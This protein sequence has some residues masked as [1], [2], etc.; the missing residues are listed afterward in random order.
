MR[1][2]SPWRTSGDKQGW[3]RWLPVRYEWFN[4]WTLAL[5]ELYNGAHCRGSL[6]FSALWEWTGGNGLDLVP[7]G[8]GRSPGPG[9][10][11]E[12]GSGGHRTCITDQLFLSARAVR[13]RGSSRHGGSEWSAEKG[14]GSTHSAE[15]RAEALLRREI[16]RADLLLPSSPGCSRVEDDLAA[17][18]FTSGEQETTFAWFWSAV[19]AD[20]C[21]YPPPAPAPGTLR[22]RYFRVLEPG[23]VIGTSGPTPL[24]LTPIPVY[25]T[26]ADILDWAQILAG[27]TSADQLRQAGA[28]GLNLICD[29]ADELFG[30]SWR[31]WI[32]PRPRRFRSSVTRKS[33]S[34][35][36]HSRPTS[37]PSPTLLTDGDDDAKH[38]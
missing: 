4:F 23:Q 21:P 33:S 15:Q 37:T 28:L 32:R 17:I 3:E 38:Q 22:G 36:P 26:V 27:P 35:W 10:R 25:M 34:S 13:S 30:S 16:S 29:Q 8:L 9:G 24:E 14:N 2:R 31:C 5:P 11:S 12:P 19:D 20:C 1:S 18:G 6:P 7:G